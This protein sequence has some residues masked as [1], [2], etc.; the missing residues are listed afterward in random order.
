MGDIWNVIKKGRFTGPVIQAGVVNLVR[1]PAVPAGLPPRGVFVGREEVLARLEEADVPVT[2]LTGLGGVGKSAL[3]V[4]AAYRSRHRFPGGVLYLDLRGYDSGRLSAHQALDALLRALGED[5]PPE[6]AAKE[7]VY[8]SRLAALDGPLL[9][10][11]DNVSGTDQ[12]GPL[13]P[14]DP[15]HRV[16]ATSRHR[17]VDRMLNLPH[18]EVDVLAEADAVALLAELARTD[19]AHA[20]EIAGLCGHLPLALRI[21]AA[22]LAERSP[23]RLVLDLSDARERLSEL[24]AGPDLAIRAAFDLSYRQLPPEE[25]RLF[26]LLAVNPGPDT[27]ATAA[28]SLAGLPQRATDRLLRSLVRAHLL[29]DVDGRYRFHDLVRLYAAECPAEDR[30]DAFLRLCDHYVTGA[31]AAT[32]RTGAAGSA[33]PGPPGLQA[34][35][36]WLDAECPNLLAAADLALAEGLP[37]YAHPLAHLL[38]EHL[39]LRRRLGDLALAFRISADSA[40]ALGHRAA[41]VEALCGMAAVQNEIGNHEGAAAC[42]QLAMDIGDEREPYAVAILTGLAQVCV[43]TGKAKDAL[44]FATA[45][46]DRARDRDEQITALVSLAV[47]VLH[48]SGPALNPHYG[49]PPDQAMAYL[50]AA[51]RM[52][53]GGRDLREATVLHGLGRAF[54]AFGRMDEAAE[55][56]LDCRAIAREIDDGYQEGLALLSLGEARPELSEDCLVQ[57]V[58]AFE[59]AGATEEADHAR[60]LLTPKG[61]TEVR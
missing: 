35:R 14:G 9:L 12:L 37:D 38:T 27:D 26:A 24:N 7:L 59:A 46:L 51:R 54:A 28:A 21:A 5:V 16:L 40:Q 2:V 56:Y 57:A 3:A 20:A 22:L 1:P 17:L 31:L 29:A 53:G 30:D 10:V 44:A 41:E 33:P 50:A 45:A 11:A 42:L 43:G 8:R 55:C 6:P 4:E 39:K 47:T 15:R 19:T 34:R 36:R 58:T 61:A 23:A 60:S 25:A 13:L 48:T 49:S 18:I 52:A 32:G